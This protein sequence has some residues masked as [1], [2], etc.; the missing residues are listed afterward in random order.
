MKKVM[1]I[2]AVLFT[3]AMFNAP[4]LAGQAEIDWVKPDSFT[5][6]RQ[7]NESKSN[8]QKR[9][10]KEFDKHFMALAAKLPEGQTLKV[11]VTNLDLAGDVRYMVGPNNAT[12]RIVDDLYFPKMK[13][14]YQLFAADNS[15]ISSNKVDIKDM[16]FN[17]GIRRSSSSNA[18]HYEK[19]MIDDWFYDT[20]PTAKDKK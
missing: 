20:F 12:I 4:A 14:D 2:I 1:N 13:F 9:V 7:A 18:F 15:V 5:D 6:I 3:T 16:G 19:N 17:H 8:F 11:S 10:F